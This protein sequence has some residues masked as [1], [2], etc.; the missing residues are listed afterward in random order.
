MED[1]RVMG[2][3]RGE[4]RDG[5]GKKEERREGQVNCREVFGEGTEG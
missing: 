1:R 5:R 4:R 2:E 3:E